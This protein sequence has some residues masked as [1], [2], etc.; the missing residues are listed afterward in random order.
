M[1]V[2]RLVKMVGV[3]LGFPAIDICLPNTGGGAVEIDKLRS[4]LKL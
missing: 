4:E 2:R 3:L 1:A